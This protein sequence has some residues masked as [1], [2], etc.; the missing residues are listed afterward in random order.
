MNR[1]TTNIGALLLFVVLS[2][3][4]TWPQARLIATH[5]PDSHDPLLSIWRIAWIAHILPTAPA[6]GQPG[7]WRTGGSRRHPRAW[8]PIGERSRQPT[9]GQSRGH[10]G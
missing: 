9:A 10:Y 3:L 2:V 8:R 6:V 1:R 5:L 7:G 4:M